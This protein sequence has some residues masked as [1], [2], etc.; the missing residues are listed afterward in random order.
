[1]A[2]AKTPTEPTGA[3][4]DAGANPY[5]NMLPSSPP[6][7]RMMPIHQSGSLIN[8]LIGSPSGPMLRL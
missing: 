4:T 3:T 2:L 5:A 6:M 1:M 7:L 8:A